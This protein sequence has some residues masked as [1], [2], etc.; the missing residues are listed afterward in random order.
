M[1]KKR[2]EEKE[3]EIKI[4]FFY[5]S[6][7]KKIFSQWNYFVVISYNFHFTWY[8][9]WKSN[10]NIN[11]IYMISIS[12]YFSLNWREIFWINEGTGESNFSLSPLFSYFLS[13]NFFPSKWKGR[14]FFFLLFSL[15]FFTVDANKRLERRLLRVQQ[16]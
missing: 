9:R 11:S 7:V 10:F 5:C 3:K 12:F 15:F 14:F 1:E 2:N 6:D 16:W 13:S 8:K 4:F